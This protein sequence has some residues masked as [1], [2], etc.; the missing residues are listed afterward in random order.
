RLSVY[1]ATTGGRSVICESIAN[2]S[3]RSLHAPRRCAWGISATIVGLLTA[4][5]STTASAEPAAQAVPTQ[6]PTLR[7]A[8][9][10][11]ISPAQGVVLIIENPNPGDSLT[12]GANVVIQGIAY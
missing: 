8:A 4:A 2:L 1:R 5:L 12:P 7:A 6:T 10:C 3:L 11:V 9:S